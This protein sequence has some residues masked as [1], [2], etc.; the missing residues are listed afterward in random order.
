MA[1]YLVTRSRITGLLA[2]ILKVRWLHGS[3]C[4][5][6]PAARERRGSY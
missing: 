3:V 5:S 4:A 2:T 1:V 6:V